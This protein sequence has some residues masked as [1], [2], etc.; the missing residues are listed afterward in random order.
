MEKTSEVLW[1]DRKR[2]I[3]GLPL[4]FTKYTLFEEKLY[5]T[6]KFLSMHEEEIRLYRIT[7]ITLRRTLF[8]RLFGVG[9]I[10]CHSSDT[11]TP[12]LE[13]RKVKNAEKVRTMLSELIEKSRKVN[14]VTM[15]EFVNS[16]GFFG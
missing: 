10:L 5:I 7:D 14:N 15:G 9:T 3:F 11:T 2:P 6:V 13:I 16:D 1:S 4:S 12:T 8:D